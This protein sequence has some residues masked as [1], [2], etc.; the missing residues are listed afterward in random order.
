MRLPRTTPRDPARL[1]ERSFAIHPLKQC[2]SYEASVHREQF[3]P[4]TISR[5]RHGRQNTLWL[6]IER[7]VDPRGGHRVLGVAHGAIHSAVE[8]RD[9]GLRGN[10]EKVD[11]DRHK[12][13]AP[14]R[15]LHC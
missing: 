13:D 1:I 6:K 2:P 5:L 14:A 15:S 9:T 4:S 3:V 8:R 10:G 12:L 7:L 11:R